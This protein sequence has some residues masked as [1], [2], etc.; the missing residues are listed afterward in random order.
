MLIYISLHS[1]VQFAGKS[2]GGFS[3]ANR[4]MSALRVTI[5]HPLIV[6]TT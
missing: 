4:I 5:G 1:F 3:T 2:I 6:F